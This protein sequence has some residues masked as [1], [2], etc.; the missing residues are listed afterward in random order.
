MI[1]M[2]GWIWRDGR[3]YCMWCV[4]VLGAP[5]EGGSIA[6]VALRAAEGLAGARGSFE[7]LDRS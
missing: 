2:E 4:C 3:V 7:Q 5:L 6:T 1:G